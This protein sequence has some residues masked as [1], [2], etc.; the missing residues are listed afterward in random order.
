MK[1]L[2][3]FLDLE[4]TIRFGQMLRAETGL[5]LQDDL[6]LSADSTTLNPHF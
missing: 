4:A 6:M 2:T 5:K 1:K 3:A